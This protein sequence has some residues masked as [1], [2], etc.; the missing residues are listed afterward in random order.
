MYSSTAPQAYRQSAVMTA[1]PMQLVVMLYDGAAKFLRQAIAAHEA[2]RAIDAGA[3]IGRAQAIVE[4]LL[5]TL[6]VEQGGE[7][8][9]QLQGFY[10]FCL[11]ELASARL[12]AK[13]DRLPAILE[14]LVELRGSWAELVTRQG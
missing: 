11:A 8:A 5:A 14:L 12:E 13:P 7:I 10:V 2:G 4:E 3:P 9:T 1:S 6:D